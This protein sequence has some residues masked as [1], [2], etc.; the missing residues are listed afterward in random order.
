[1]SRIENNVAANVADVVRAPQVERDRQVQVEQARADQVTSV[2][3]AASHE[4]DA[5]DV[6]T[7]VAQIQKVIE[8]AS[9]RN[10]DFQVTDDDE[11]TLEIRDRQTD[12]VIKQIPGEAVLELRA[13]L[14]D[15]VGGFVDEIV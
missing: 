11:F 9:N 15:L 5:D 1:M 3:G 10:L 4:V 13:R 12:E 2:E 7:A 8:T 14:D 6:K